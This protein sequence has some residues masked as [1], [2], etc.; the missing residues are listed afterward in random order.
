MLKILLSVSLASSLVVAQLYKLSDTYIDRINAETDSWTAGRNFPANLTEAYLRTHLIAEEKHFARFERPVPSERKTF[1]ATWFSGALPDRFD[2]R[3]RWPNCASI[4]LVPDIGACLQPHVYAAVAAFRDRRCIQ[5]AGQHQ[6]SLSTE[7]VAACC[8]ICRYDVVAVCSH[9][10]VYRT[11]QFLHKRGAVTGGEYGD[12]SGCQPASIPPCSHYD[13]SPA[14][15]KCENVPRPHLKC[16]TRCTN[17]K[18]GRDFF[19]DKHRTTL[20]YWVDD[21]EDA[22]KRE[23]MTFGPTTATFELYDDFYHY[24][25]GVYHHSS[26]AKSE[27]YLHSGKLIGWGTEN[28]T[29]YWL[30]LNTWGPNWGDRGSFKIVRGK[31]ECD[32]EYLVAAG[33]PRY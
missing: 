4:G 10:S 33:K 25:T 19:Q 27:M 12:Q 16:H 17:E 6:E 20:A 23:L 7:Y 1:D 28:G 15:V 24:K 30:V 32:F 3:E 26:E 21:K 2:A 14:L 31:F 9:G 29:P 22:I 18:Y 11:W 13:S 8:K 5:T